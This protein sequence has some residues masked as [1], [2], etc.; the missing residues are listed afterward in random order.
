MKVADFQPEQYTMCINGHMV[1]A[2]VFTHETAKEVELDPSCVTALLPLRPLVFMGRRRSWN[3]LKREA[4]V[5]VVAGRWWAV[6]GF[7]RSCHTARTRAMRQKLSTSSLSK[8]ARLYPEDL[9]VNRASPYGSGEHG[10]PPPTWHLL[11]CQG[12]LSIRS[13]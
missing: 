13:F 1:Q 8:T 7:I 2:L 11:Q 12:L 5:I 10:A 6:L 3:R 9:E 4:R